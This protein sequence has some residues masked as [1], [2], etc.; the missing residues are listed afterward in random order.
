MTVVV[1]AGYGE[2][3]YGE[4]QGFENGKLFG[5]RVKKSDYLVTSAVALGCSMLLM[6][7]SFLQSKKLKR[8]FGIAHLVLFLWTVFQVPSFVYLLILPQRLE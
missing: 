5:P 4:S 3:I 6:G 1:S 2:V 8:K 7:V